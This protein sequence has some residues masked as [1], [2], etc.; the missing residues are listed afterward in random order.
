MKQPNIVLIV[1]DALRAQNLSCYGY[2][3][4]TTPNIDRLAGKGVLFENAFSC[5]N[6]TDP[7]FTTIFSGKYPAVHG[8]LKHGISDKEVFQK[9]T[10]GLPTLAT[11]L[12]SHGYYT[13]AIDWLGRWHK[14]GFDSYSG[15]LTRTGG[16][17][18]GNLEGRIRRFKPARVI[19]DLLSKSSIN[20][21][22]MSKVYF[23]YDKA[24]PVTDRALREIK[25]RGEHPFFLF[26][27]YW[28]THVPYDP[29]KE[30]RHLFE[31]ADYRP[32]VEKTEDTWRNVVN[33]NWQGFLKRYTRKM[34]YTREVLARYDGSLHYIDSQLGR[35]IRELEGMGILDDTIFVFTADHGE[36]LTEHGIFFDHHG[37]YEELIHVPLVMSY[38]KAV[39]ANRVKTAVQHPDLLPTV[40]DLAGIGYSS[41]DIDGKSLVP[42]FGEAGINHGFH[43]FVY[44]EEERL[45]RKFAVR[46][47]KYKYIFAPS[48]NDA[49]CK[50]CGVVHGGVE[51][52]YDII[53]DPFE[54]KN[55]VEANTEIRDKMREAALSF[56]A[57]LKR[58]RERQKLGNRI[59]RIKR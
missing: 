51:E 36:S 39:P 48:E 23:A 30:H 49:L 12:H 5:I 56:A 18:D 20:R 57:E 55:I 7:S 32:A 54:T 9:E 41:A 35:L 22:I 38:P 10:E 25:K 21:E 44:A 1:A 47:E 43:P 14:A 40:L 6:V 15:M 45:E 17:I 37:L 26:I 2:P 50:Y 34:K 13:V 58:K 31:K 16:F 52:L 59:I 46:G 19:I 53:N 42:L 28:D 4:P 33:P 11:I 27:H 3:R 24:G 8:I 29:P